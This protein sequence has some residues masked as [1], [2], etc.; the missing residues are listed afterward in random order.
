MVLHQDLAVLRSC[1]LFFY[2][3]CFLVLLLSSSLLCRLVFGLP[4]EPARRSEK[5]AAADE[6]PDRHNV[7]GAD[8]DVR[9]VG[10]PPILPPFPFETCEPLMLTRAPIVSLFLELGLFAPGVLPDYDCECDGQ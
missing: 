7:E 4:S 3:P 2:Y 8:S 10:R 5:E 1:S 9:G 6:T